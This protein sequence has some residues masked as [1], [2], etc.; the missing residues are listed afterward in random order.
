MS[1]LLPVDGRDI[2]MAYNGRSAT[3]RRLAAST[4]DNPLDLQKDPDVIRLL[5]HQHLR[6]F[7]GGS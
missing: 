4:F 6:L 1:R 7:P 3:A 5:H 2:E